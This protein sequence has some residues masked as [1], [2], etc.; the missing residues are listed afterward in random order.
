MVI[1]NKVVLASVSDYR[2]R[3][4]FGVTIGGLMRVRT[5]RNASM[6]PTICAK[7]VQYRCNDGE[8]RSDPIVIEGSIVDDDVLGTVLEF[9]CPTPDGSG[10]ENAILISVSE[11]EKLQ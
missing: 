8:F 5:A 1:E 9:V 10:E 4:G 7:W 2:T 6:S 3:V 11:L